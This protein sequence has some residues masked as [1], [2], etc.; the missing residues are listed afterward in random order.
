MTNTLK[1]ILRRRCP[2]CGIESKVTHFSV[3]EIPGYHNNLTGKNNAIV[4]HLACGHEF[5]DGKFNIEK[6]YFTAPNKPTAKVQES[7]EQFP[8]VYITYMKPKTFNIFDG[9]CALCLLFLAF[10]MPPLAIFPLF[11]FICRTK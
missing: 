1:H 6:I 9:I 11:Y 7:A 4:E 3:R 8:P 10:T 2:Y 5:V